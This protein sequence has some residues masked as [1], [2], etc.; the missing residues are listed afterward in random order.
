MHGFN[1]GDRV[2]ALMR[3]GWA[4]R[5]RVN[6]TSVIGIPDDM[7]FEVTATIPMAFTTAYYSLRVA[8][9]IQKG[10]TVLLH[11]ASGGVWQAAIHRDAH[12]ASQIMGITGG[13]GVDIVVNFLAGEL[14]QQSFNCIAPF[15][16]FVE[17]GKR[18]L[19]QNSQLEMHAF[20]RHVSFSSVDL[21][22]P[23]KHKGPIASQ[24]MAEVMKLTQ[25][26]G[27]HPIQSIT[28][29]PIPRIEEAFRMLQA[30]KHI[31]KIVVVPHSEDQVADAVFENMSVEDYT[32][33]IRPKVRGTWNLHQVLSDMGL[34]HFV[35]LSSLAGIT[36]NVSQAN[37][38]A[39]GT[40]QDAIT[41]HRSARGLPAV[42]IDLGMV[43]EVGYV[44]ETD[45]V[46][47]R[48]ERMGFQALEEGDVL[49][50]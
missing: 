5:V 29:Y 45:G 2:C 13:K 7:S 21:I 43:K 31:G 20:T 3:G 1:A 37:Y 24:I 27:V 30:G 35:M 12:F 38:S 4:N 36:G 49:G 42:S 40:F 14:L 23:G 41:R 6:W 50:A 47:T 9:H 10:E 17:I 44:A 48:L 8:A 26:G 34:D 18:D 28:T 19:E 16:R 39:G 32:A 11:S 33:A 15:E 46:A 25:G 22:A